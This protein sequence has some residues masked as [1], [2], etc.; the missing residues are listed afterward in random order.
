[1]F[2]RPSLRQTKDTRL[3]QGRKWCMINLHFCV[4]VC[5]INLHFCVHVSLLTTCKTLHLCKSL[6]L[7]ILRGTMAS[8]FVCN[9]IRFLIMYLMRRDIISTYYYTYNVHASI[10]SCFFF[11]FSMHDSPPSAYSCGLG[12]ERGRNTAGWRRRPDRPLR[13]R[14]APPLKTCSSPPGLLSHMSSCG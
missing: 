6:H 13:A 7:R 4:H 14:D 5:M 12:R 1:M 10:N 2:L 3:S 8:C 9:G 11:S